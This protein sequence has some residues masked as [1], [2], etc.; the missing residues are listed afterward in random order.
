LNISLLRDMDEVQLVGNFW[1]CSWLIP[2]L[3]HQRLHSGIHFVADEAQKYEKQ[4][5]SVE[6]D[7]YDPSR[8]NL[9][10]K[11]LVLRHV[12]VVHSKGEKGCGFL[13]EDDEVEQKFNAIRTYPRTFSFNKLLQEEFSIKA[14]LLWT[15][16]G[17]FM[18]VGL[19]RLGKYVF[20]RSEK[21][22]AQLR[23]SQQILPLQER[24]ASEINSCLIRP[25]SINKSRA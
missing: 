25:N 22:G 19:I 6:I 11:Q 10:K 20:D 8:N 15:A 3:V 4:F 16:V 12:I 5:N 23:A 18:V 21:R 1:Q 17:V 13:D 24:P 2:E 14:C 9:T 7:C